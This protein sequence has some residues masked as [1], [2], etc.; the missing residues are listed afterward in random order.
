MA[1]RPVP[2]WPLYE[3]SKLKARLIAWVQV[4]GSAK[5]PRNSQDQP[6][7]GHFELAKITLYRLSRFYALGNPRKHQKTSP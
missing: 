3:K 2:E 5:N 7:K 6:L 4:V 1:S